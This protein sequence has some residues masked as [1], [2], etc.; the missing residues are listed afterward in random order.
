MLLHGLE[1]RQATVANYDLD[2]LNDNSFLLRGK[3]EWIRAFL[4]ADYVAYNNGDV[5]EIRPRA[6]HERGGVDQI[7]RSRREWK[8]RA[9]ACLM[10]RFSIQQALVHSS[11][12]WIQIVSYHDAQRRLKS[13]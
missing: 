10:K 12:L 7:V 4:T 5:T 8:P 2:R 6:A 1:E 11:S 3:D 9:A 13:E